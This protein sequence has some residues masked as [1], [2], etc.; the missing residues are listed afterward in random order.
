MDLIA[1]LSDE[2]LLKRAQED[3]ANVALVYDRYADKVYGFFIK[4]CGH[5]ETAEDLTSKTFL[6]FLEALPTLTWTGAP[7]SAWLFRVAT[8]L[9]TDHWRLASTKRD[10]ALDEDDWDPPSNDDPSWTAEIKIEGDKLRD[11]M[12]ALPSRDQEVLGM[13]FFAG[14]ENQEIAQSLG[15]SDNHAA[16]LTYRAVGRLRKLL[17]PKTA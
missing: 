9:L 2:Q 16:V 1:G 8:N 13:R 10:T 6:K 17:I 3:R 11:A 5:K 4:R 14:L 15:V 12:K 7:L